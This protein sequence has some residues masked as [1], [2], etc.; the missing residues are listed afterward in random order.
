MIRMKL[1]VV[2]FLS[3]M[4]GLIVP[5]LSYASDSPP[6]MNGEA[7][8][9]RVDERYITVMEQRP[10]EEC[11][12]IT[13]NTGSNSTSSGTPEI[14]GL[15]VGGAIG[16]QLDDDGDTGATI[17]AILGA[18][19]ASDLEKKK[20]Q[21]SGTT[22]TELR[23]DTVHREV[24]VQRLDGYNVTYEYNNRLFTWTMKR[25]PGAT[26]PVKIYVLPDE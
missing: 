19:I 26:I 1:F 24:Q 15:L 10:V 13:V 23:C 7:R 6:S 9:V 25:R 21:R 4:I 22:S 8:V 20:S 2:V 5:A 12:N 17:G 3:G 11:R 14:L 18:S 16:N